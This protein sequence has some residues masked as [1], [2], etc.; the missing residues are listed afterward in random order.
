MNMY[1]TYNA[2]VERGLKEEPRNNLD[3][4]ILC[5]SSPNLVDVTV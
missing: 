5:A 3:E 1:N 2:V 4:L